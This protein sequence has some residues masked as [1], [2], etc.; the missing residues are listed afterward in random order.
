MVNVSVKLSIMKLYSTQLQSIQCTVYASLLPTE[1]IRSFR[2]GSVYDHEFVIIASCFRVSDTKIR[3]WY[4]AIR[5]TTEKFSNSNPNPNP[6]MSTAIF[7]P[8]VQTLSLHVLSSQI[9]IY[10]NTLNKTQNARRIEY[11]TRQ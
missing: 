6:V 4:Q 5:P 2:V 10:K 7:K 1:C 8:N 3:P 9:K 11:I